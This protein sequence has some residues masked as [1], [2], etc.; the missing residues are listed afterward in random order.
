[1]TDVYVAFA[2][3]LALLDCDLGDTVFE[4]KE[5]ITFSDQS[6]SDQA[7]ASMLGGGSLPMIVSLA[8]LVVSV[9]GM[10]VTLSLKKKLEPATI[11]DE[12]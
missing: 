6:L 5:R 10:G 2:G 9:A 7:V 3:T 12:D 8:A 1:M 4:Q 11:A